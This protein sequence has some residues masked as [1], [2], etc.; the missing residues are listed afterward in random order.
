[1]QRIIQRQ[2]NTKELRS[3]DLGWGDIGQKWSIH[4]VQRDA[5]GQMAFGEC[6][7]SDN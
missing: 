1:M 5:A 2:F 6:A 3:L 7:L 4:T